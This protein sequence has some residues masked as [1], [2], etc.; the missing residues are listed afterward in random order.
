MEHDVWMYKA[1]D[2]EIE[3]R[4]F[5]AGEEIPDGWADSPEA[6]NR[7]YSSEAVDPSDVDESGEVSEAAAP[8]TPKKK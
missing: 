4:L 7:V 2:G 5:A 3:A 1:T 6:A 8:P